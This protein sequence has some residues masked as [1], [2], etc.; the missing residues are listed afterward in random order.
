MGKIKGWKKV[1]V[2]KW[3]NE[4]GLFVKV[5]TKELYDDYVFAVS[6]PKNNVL[7]FD[8]LEEANKEAVNYMR[9]NPF[10]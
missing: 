4:S 7:F 5:V 1:A 6:T 9:L 2:N 3:I 8:T 10:G